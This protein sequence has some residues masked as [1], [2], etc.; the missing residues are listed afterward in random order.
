MAS[1]REPLVGIVLSG[2]HPFPPGA[3]KSGFHG[4]CCSFVIV[5]AEIGFL[6]LVNINREHLVKSEFETT[7]DFLIE[8]CMSHVNIEFIP[9]SFQR[10]IL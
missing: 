6:A 3:E 7:N 2:K 4:H 1:Q 9:G 8:M 10:N 5:A